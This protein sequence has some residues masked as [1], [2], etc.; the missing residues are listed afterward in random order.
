[1]E[2]IS[3]SKKSA[4]SCAMIKYTLLPPTSSPPLGLKKSQR[5][6]IQQHDQNFSNERK[7]AKK[8]RLG[9]EDPIRSN[10]RSKIQKVHPQSNIALEKLKQ[11]SP[12]LPVSLVEAEWS[13]WWTLRSWKTNT[14][15]DLQRGWSEDPSLIR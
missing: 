11:G 8:R 2:T 3:R 9:S 1:M 6:L 13:L 10:I 14:F 4:K 5:K 15:V 7:A 12:K